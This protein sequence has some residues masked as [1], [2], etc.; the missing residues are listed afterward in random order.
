MHTL[1]FFKKF[2]SK[3]DF[4]CLYTVEINVSDALVYL[5]NSVLS[6]GQNTKYLKAIYVDLF[7]LSAVTLKTLSSLMMLALHVFRILDQIHSGSSILFQ[8]SWK[9]LV[10]CIM[11]NVNICLNGYLVVK[12]TVAIVKR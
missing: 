10:T 5:H 3:L 11:H 9:N 4:Y 1:R 12:L 7:K 6:C 8:A 2:R